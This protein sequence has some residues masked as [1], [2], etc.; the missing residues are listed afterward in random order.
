MALIRMFVIRSTRA[1]PVL[2]GST[3]TLKKVT[4]FW[5]ELSP[6]YVRPALAAVIGAGSRAGAGDG[7]C[8]VRV[9]T[10]QLCICRA[11]QAA[12]RFIDEQQNFRP[13]VGIEA[14]RDR[15]I[16]RN[17]QVYRRH[18]FTHLGRRASRAGQRDI[19]DTFGESLRAYRGNV[20]GVRY[21]SK[22]RVQRDTQTGEKQSS[23]KYPA[24]PRGRVCFI[25]VSQ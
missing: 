5:A 11:L 21:A 22:L 25:T 8:A 12:S 15:R 14:A 3:G 9:V 19:A 24:R 7:A 6:E 23:S 10:G 17:R 18:E 4:P 1:V 20:R 13:R 16:Q 2:G